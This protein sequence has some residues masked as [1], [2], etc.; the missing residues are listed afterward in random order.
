MEHEH[1][2]QPED[3][4]TPEDRLAAALDDLRELVKDFSDLGV[5]KDFRAEQPTV[6]L[7]ARTREA[8]SIADGLVYYC[9]ERHGIIPT[10]VFTGNIEH[11]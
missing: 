11:Q 10:V 7:N 2:L 9:T 4:Q 8:A 6:R 5:G 1:S 3:E